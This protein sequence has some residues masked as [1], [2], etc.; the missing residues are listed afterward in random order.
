MHNFIK[1]A[2]AMLLGVGFLFAAGGVPATPVQPCT[3][4]GEETVTGDGNIDTYW[5]CDG[6]EWQPYK[7]CQWQG[8]CLYL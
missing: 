8:A 5:R 2:A 4:A 1:H 3:V 7:I 6:S